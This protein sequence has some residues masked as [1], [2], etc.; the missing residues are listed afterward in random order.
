MDR[1]EGAP[2][3][4]PP[5]AARLA[6]SHVARA[7]IAVSARTGAEP[8]PGLAAEPVYEGLVTRAIGFTLDAAL[9]NFVA[10]VVG[11]ALALAVSVLQLPDELDAAAAACAGVA[12]VLWTV[13]YF[14][15]FWSSTGQTPGDRLMRIRVVLADGGGE[16]RPT[17]AL[18]RL[19]ALV[20]AALPLFAGFL[21][22]L[23]DDRRRG[24]HDMLAGTVVVAAPDDV[25]APAP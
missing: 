12:Y 23:V 19:G 15:T 9:V 1:G 3:A 25:S 17:R 11:A 20:L 10:L 21:P 2:R 4:A 18:V 14:V 7:P 8:E 13:A 16:L 5:P 6:V 24:L 22:I